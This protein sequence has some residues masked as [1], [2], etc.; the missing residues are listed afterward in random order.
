MTLTGKINYRRQNTAQVVTRL[1]GGPT[2]FLTTG[3]NDG[4][5]ELF[6]DYSAQVGYEGEKLNIVGGLTGRMLVS[7]DGLDFG[8]RTFHQFTLAASLNRGQLRP[9]VM[10]RFPRD[11]D[12]RSANNYIFGLTLGIQLNETSKTNH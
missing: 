7:E 5:T 3:G 9:G 4:D 1:R 2:V 12:V 8:E 11:D 6:F 10:L